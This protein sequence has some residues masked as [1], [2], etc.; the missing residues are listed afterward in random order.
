MKNT[1]FWLAVFYL[2]SLKAVAQK[3][4]DREQYLLKG[5]IVNQ[6]NDE[7]LPLVTVYNITKKSGVTSDYSGKFS[8]KFQPGDSIIFQSLGFENLVWSTFIVSSEELYETIRMQQKTYELKSVD[9]TAFRTAEDFKKHILAMDMPEEKKLEIPGLNMVRPEDFSGEGKIV[10]SGP[11]SFLYDKFSRRAIDYKRF[12]VTKAGYERQQMLALKY[13]KEVVKKI[14]KVEDP[15]ELEEF[16]DFCN[17][18]DAFI[19]S[20]NEYDLIVAVN[21]CYDEFKLTKGH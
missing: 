21:N 2:I 16:M 6:E 4:I 20:A 18:Q 15:D 12:L 19:D 13:N 7:P 8:I 5:L 3:N 14:I 11:I 10:I 17:L 1:F 9:V